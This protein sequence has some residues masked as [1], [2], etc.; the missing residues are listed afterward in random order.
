MTELKKIQ[1][2]E[3]LTKMIIPTDKLSQLVFDL[4]AEEFRDLI[5]NHSPFGCVEKETK[6]GEVV[7]NFFLELAEEYEGKLPPD[8]FARETFYFGVSAYEQNYRT[9]SFSMAFD[10]LT[11][12]TE[13]RGVRKEQYDALKAAFK[14][15]NGIQITIDLKPLLN[16]FPKY[17]QNYTGKLMEISGSLLPCQLIETEINGQKVCAVN[18]LA[19]SPLM[20][21]AKIK[22]QLLSYSTAP[23]AI[24]GQNNTPKIITVKNYLLRRIHLMKS[25][26]RKSGLNNSIL[27]ETIYRQCGLED[28]TRWQKRDVRKEIE[29]I[30]NH[31]KAEGVFQDFEIERENGAYRAIKILF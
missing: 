12:G 22:R 1:V 29:G 23:L 14:R 9:I 21:V 24:V 20:R 28:A 10:G 26:K 8:P 4:T 16:A 15:L 11:G 19:E 18:L 30:L 27:F 25:V 31:F 6:R 2:Q 17:C 13:K 7:T 5:E 3:R